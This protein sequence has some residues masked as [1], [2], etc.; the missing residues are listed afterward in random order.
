MATLEEGLTDRIRA[1]ID[2]DQEAMLSQASVVQAVIAEGVP[3]HG[4]RTYQLRG[5]HLFNEAGYQC[6]ILKECLRPPITPSLRKP[7]PIRGG[8]S[9]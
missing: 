4:F 5:W 1:L 6:T 8:Q 2:E 9:R 7:E 3:S